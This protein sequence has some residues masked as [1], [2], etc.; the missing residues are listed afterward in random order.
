MLRVF[1]PVSLQKKEAVQAF[2][3]EE[4]RKLIRYLITSLKGF[5]EK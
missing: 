4:Q 1:T 3:I 2:E 5:V